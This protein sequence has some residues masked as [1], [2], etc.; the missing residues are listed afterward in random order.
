MGRR[1]GSLLVVC[2]LVDVAAANDQDLYER[3]WPETPNSTRLTLSQQITDQ[4][5]VLGNTVGH[6]VNTLSNDAIALGF[7]GRRRRAKVRLGLDDRHDRYL[8]FKLAGDVHFTHGVARVAARI[9]IG[10]AG[11]VL[12]LELPDVEMA[13]VAYRGERGVEIRVPLFK[14]SF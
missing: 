7:D 5:T 10:I 1:W 2:A 4:L 3:L 8:T 13:P 6:H 14:R 12:H 9:D 11:H